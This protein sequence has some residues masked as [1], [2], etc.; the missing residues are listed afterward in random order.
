MRRIAFLVVLLSLG[1]ALAFGQASKQ[2][3]VTVK[4][5]QVRATPSYMGKVLATLKYGDRIAVLSEQSGW[6]RVKVAAGE[7]W[8]NLSAL[9]TKQIVMQAGAQNVSTTASSGEVAL[10]GK[11]FNKEVEEQYKSETSLDYTWVD[12]MG[13]YVVSP[14]QVIAFLQQG[15][16]NASLGGVQ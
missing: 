14:E 2:M 13:G 11:G 15:A 9:T 5:T 3:S 6:A 16:L 7:G 10:A 8:V 1:S 4:E 12:Q